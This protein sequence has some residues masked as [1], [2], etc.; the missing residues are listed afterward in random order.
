MR[1]SEEFEREDP[2]FEPVESSN[3]DKFSDTESDGV[4]VSSNEEFEGSSLNWNS[5][6]LVSD[7]EIETSSLQHPSGSSDPFFLNSELG[8]MSYMWPSSFC[9]NTTIKC[10]LVSLTFLS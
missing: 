3:G 8:S 9:V 1:S 6:L 2:F 7:P 5:E 4:S 10:M